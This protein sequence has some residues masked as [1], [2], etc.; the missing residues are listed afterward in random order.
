[1]ITCTT[2]YNLLKRYKK[3]RTA[4]VFALLVSLFFTSTSFAQDTTPEIDQDYL[5]NLTPDKVTWKKA[6]N[7]EITAGKDIVL[8][9]G[10]SYN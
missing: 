1:M 5:N 8:I 6:T 7:D 3:A 4:P 10:T 9:D 2:F